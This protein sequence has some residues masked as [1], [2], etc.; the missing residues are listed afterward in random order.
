MSNARNLSELST[1]ITSSSNRIGI[2]EGLIPTTSTLEVLRSIAAKETTSES[3]IHVINSTSDVYLFNSYT[4]DQVGL[5]DGSASRHLMFY[6]RPN[7]YWAFHT[8]AIERLRIDSAGNLGLGS[9]P[10]RSISNYTFATINGTNA[11]GLDMGYGGSR[12]FSTVVDSGGVYLT[13][14]SNTQMSFGTND[15]ERVRIDNSGNLLI[16]TTNISNNRP[17][18]NNNGSLNLFDT[19]SY[20]AINQTTSSTAGSNGGWVFIGDDQGDASTGY[21]RCYWQLAKQNPGQAGSVTYE[22]H[23]RGDV[24]YHYGG[25]YHLRL[26]FWYSADRNL[27]FNSASLRCISGKRD[28]INV[29]LYKNGQGVWLYSNSSWGYIT[30]RKIHWEDARERGAAYCACENNGAL[31]G[32]GNQTT[33]P[34]GSVYTLQADGGYYLTNLTTFNG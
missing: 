28:G 2:G 24:N 4:A 22:I 23:H 10:Y 30:A 9:P 26:N 34:S 20:N 27:F 19:G 32:T 17:L 13:N 33:L 8:A 12:K 16:G 25:T 18:V 3:S 6:N 7:S 1:I 11:S 21:A 29:V 31:N 14:A 15:V 5:Y